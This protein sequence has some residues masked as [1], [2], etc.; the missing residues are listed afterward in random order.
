[1]HVDKGF[2]DALNLLGC[3]FNVQSKLESDRTVGA[4]G[5]KVNFDHAGLLLLHTV[6]Q[7][8]LSESQTCL[9]INYLFDFTLDLV[10]EFCQVLSQH[11][12]N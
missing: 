3:S 11:V 10:L 6:D 8:H 7:T 4:S 9:G 2:F 1:M 12:E 5:H